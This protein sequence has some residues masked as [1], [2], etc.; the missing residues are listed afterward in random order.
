MKTRLA[1][2]SLGLLLVLTVQEAAAQFDFFKKLTGGGPRR[3]KGYIPYAT[4]GLGAGSS[5]YY[6]E[7]SLYSAVIPPLASVRWNVSANYTRHL[8]PRWAARIGLTWARIAGDD[9][10]LRNSRPELFVRNLHFRN[11]IKELSIVGVYSLVNESRNFQF[12]QKLVPYVF[13]GIALAAHN[14]VARPDSSLGLGTGWV[15][16]QPL[17]TEGQG[18]AGGPKPYGLVQIAVPFG[19]GVRYKINSRLDVS[20]EVGFRYTFTDYLDDVSTVYV[21][22]GTLGSQL[23]QSLSNRSL[24]PIAAQVGKDRTEL[25]RQY[26]IDNFNFPTNPN[27]NPLGQPIPNYDTGS[28]RGSSKRPDSYLITCLQLNYVITGKV[29]CPPTYRK[30]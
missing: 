29:K 11:D 20:F 19:A 1:F 10:Y 26:L 25:V 15:D 13:G 24:E 28:G 21:D 3:Q 22:P 8:N 18:L 5:H 6:G 30:M 23:A 4:V 16:L 7:M 2:L 27:I 14:P 12:R 9:Y 17:G